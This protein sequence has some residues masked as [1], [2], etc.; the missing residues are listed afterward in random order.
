[1]DKT[2]TVL[3]ALILLGTASADVITPLD[4]PN[5]GFE[6][7]IAGWSAPHGARDLE[8]AF[9]RSG[10]NCVRLA[11]KDP[12]KDPVYITRQVPV[13]EGGEYEVECHVK[14]EGI[15]AR[16]GR[17]P[18][19]GAGLI[20]EWA[21]KTGKWCDAGQ[22]AC[23]LYG[24][25][26]WTHR[27]ITRLTAPKGAGYAIVFLALRGAGAAWFD[28]V[29]FSRVTPAIEKL[30][31][32]DGSTID[33]NTPHFAWKLRP[34]VRRY[35]LELSQDPAFA[36]AV[37]AYDVG[38]LAEYQLT[39]P[40]AKGR[41]WWRITSDGVGDARSASFAQTADPSRDCLP[42]RP[43]VK[44]VRVT[45]ARESFRLT[46]GERVDVS[47]CG[48]SGKLEQ[49][50]TGA[51]VYRFDA[52][53][54][55][56]KSG[57]AAD[58]LVAV[59]AAGNAF[60]GRFP[61]L[62]APKPA[63]AVRI[64]ADGRYAENGQRI[65]PLGIYEVSKKYMAEVCAAGWEIVHTYRWE[66]SQDDV[67]CR[68]YL[69]DCRE[70]GLRAFIGFDRGAHSKK[71]LVQGNFDMV[72]RRVGA[73]ADHP[74]LFCWYLFD[75]PEI[76]DQ[77]IPPDQLIA[78]ADLIRALDPYHPV[79]MTTWNRTMN[80]YRRS[81]DTHW[82]QAYGDATEVTTTL[83]SHVK[84]TKG[85][86]PITLLVNCND[87]EQ[88]AAR[89]RGK[90]P[91]PT[92]FSRDYASL[93]ACAFLGIVRNCNGVW[94]WWFARDCKEYYTAAQCPKAWEDLKRV[95]AE[96][97]RARDYANLPGE[98]KMGEAKVG[99]DIV[100]WWLKK[101]GEKT[102]FIAINASKNPVE[103]EL[104]LPGFG[105]RKFAFTRYEVKMDEDFK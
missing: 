88:G 13:S 97:R 30:E 86:S 69:D 100:R 58:A 24:T 72:A 56:W 101:T 4:I 55:G 12:M 57:L 63:N 80:E 94:W 3:A 32:A 99:K 17:M 102:V 53:A 39:E 93:K 21:D 34:G 10:T 18:S 66:G 37:R 26:D 27:K 44:A 92:R 31:P 48:V 50:A 87:Q 43:T 38:G 1:M 35:R 60:C 49:E 64:D 52:P 20:V 8:T 2:S 46:F 42:P 61:F 59:D 68:M 77:F 6:S 96:I 70:N 22:Y 14:T 67:A 54:D 103:A 65:F 5:M 47:V 41:W 23:G 74:G 40:L 19:V 90:E 84:F 28:D 51:F 73:L 45:D 78:F 104:D 29:T 71:G 98:P 105:K 85:E 16:K 83:D 79:V 76:I 7:G 82:T 95:V 15:E 62:F 81:W 36:S 9:G 75:E 33:C 25:N 89:R 91:D 11:V